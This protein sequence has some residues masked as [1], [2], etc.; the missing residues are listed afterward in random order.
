MSKKKLIEVGQEIFVTN[1]GGFISTPKPNLTKWIV[2]KANKSSFYADPVG[3]ESEHPARFNQKD[4]LYKT[5][6]G[7]N[8][9]AY[10]TE[11]EY[12]NLISLKEQYDELH[13]YC[14][15]NMHKLGI[16]DLEKVKEM[17]DYK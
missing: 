5:G 8:F 14:T 1:L 2:L 9:K 6:W 13:Q 7:Q 10:R 17:I 4:M 15:R 16:G 3:R 11:E 12:W